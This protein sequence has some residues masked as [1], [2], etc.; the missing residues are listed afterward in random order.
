MVNPFDRFHADPAIDPKTTDRLMYR[1]VEASINEGFAD[2]T[3]TPDVPQPG[4][5]ITAKYHK[6]KWQSWGLKLAQPVFGAV[7][8]EHRGWYRK[9]LS[10]INYHLRDIGAEYTYLC[11][12]LTNK[13]VIW[14]WEGLGYRF[15]RG[16]LI[17]RKL[18]R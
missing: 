2:I 3:I 5:F 9:I 1:W 17:F 4:A 18:L 10:E 14:V 15:G 7:S 8:P 11:T 16:E 12:Q 6:D 13:A